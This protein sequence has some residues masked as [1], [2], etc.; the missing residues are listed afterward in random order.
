MNV[1][2]PASDRKIFLSPTLCHLIQERLEEW[3][4]L[5]S[6]SVARPDESLAA[7]WKSPFPQEAFGKATHTHFSL[8]S[9]DAD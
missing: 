5:Q 1:I 8:R 4:R 9:I 7:V 3:H 2:G 6:R